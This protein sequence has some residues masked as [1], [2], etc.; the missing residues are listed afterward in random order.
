MRA[1]SPIMHHGGSNCRKT[2]G[3]GEIRGLYTPNV[4]KKEKKTLIGI[5]Q[6]MRFLDCYVVGAESSP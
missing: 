3:G 2:I 6:L 4:W 1:T 5:Y